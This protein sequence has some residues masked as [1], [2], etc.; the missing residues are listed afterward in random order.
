[1]FNLSP[2]KGVIKTDIPRSISIS[3]KMLSMMESCS[4]LKTEDTL[5]ITAKILS[6]VKSG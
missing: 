1:M 5:C 6:R 4:P 2:I 3:M